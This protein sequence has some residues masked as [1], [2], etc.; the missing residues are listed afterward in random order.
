[1]FPVR[2]KQGVLMKSRILALASATSAAALLS[3]CSTT[4]VVTS[5]KVEAEASAE[6]LGKRT[7]YLNYFL[8]QS[9]LTVSLKK[10]G[11]GG[12]DK[13]DTPPTVTN[14]NT[15]TIQ[16]GKPMEKPREPKPEAAA[17]AE[18][19]PKKTAC[20]MLREGYKKEREAQIQFVANWPNRIAELQAVASGR[21]V[22]AAEQEAA[23]KAYN[24]LVADVAT[25]N[26]RVDKAALLAQGLND[27]CPVKVAIEVTLSVEP[28]TN[29]PY[30]LLV[31]DDDASADTVSAKVDAKGLLTSV[32]TTADERT[33]TIVTA[34]LKSVG[35]VLGAFSPG[36]L[37]AIGDA[38]VLGVSGLTRDGGR[39]G[40]P[41]PAFPQKFRAQVAELAGKAPM[42]IPE[43][44]P[45][46]PDYDL[47][48][49]VSELLPKDAT[50]G[51]IR[52]AQTGYGMHLTCS[53]MP[54]DQAPDEPEQK[55]AKRLKAKQGVL[56]SLPR[57]CDIV[58]GK[59][60]QGSDAPKSL[61]NYTEQRRTFAS[62]VDSRYPLRAPLLRTQLITR[63]HGYEFVDGRITSVIYEKPS[64]TEAAVALP[65]AAVGALFSGVVSGIQGP[66]SVTKAQA[67]RLDA[68]AAAYTAEAAL[69]EARTKAQD[70]ADKAEK[71][72]AEAASEAATTEE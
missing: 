6:K 18:P 68:Q 58:V 1:M 10:A 36:D 52:F 5:T 57:A 3:A 41:D 40:G 37:K 55:G 50:T 67:E 20:D 70:A 63:K 32:S 49:R 15:I 19:D 53:A 44:G 25:A 9:V 23:L 11:G 7:V 51:G 29:E 34:S 64:S 17:A 60:T 2:G 26:A 59:V 42:M 69:I 30:A 47:R 14:T 16:N 71:A 21:L 12:D 56:V 27:A 66:Q 35:T 39:A 45:K 28:D 62:V 4:S 38:K 8:P 22:T 43:L 13:K 46:L 48:Y 72:K 24:A 65:G 54:G 31:E 33:G 61:A